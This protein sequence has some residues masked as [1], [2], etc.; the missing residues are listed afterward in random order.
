MDPLILTTL[1]ELQQAIA[2]HEPDLQE[3]PIESLK[4]A[5]YLLIVKTP[6]LL[7]ITV[8]PF[9]VNQLEYTLKEVVYTLATAFIAY[10]REMPNVE[11]LWGENT[12]PGEDMLKAKLVRYSSNLY[13]CSHAYPETAMESNLDYD[14]RQ[15]L[16]FL[17]VY[18]KTKGIELM[19]VADLVFRDYV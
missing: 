18:L 19:Q 17:Y 11:E 16:M 9:S 7:Q 14:L 15:Y 3:N 5:S 4:A 6:E 12:E 8:N 10:E 1:L 2:R 13:A